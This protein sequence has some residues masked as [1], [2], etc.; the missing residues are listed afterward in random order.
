MTGK[1][2]QKVLLINCLLDG[3]ADEF[4]TPVAELCRRHTIRSATFDWRGKYG[5]IDA[6]LISPLRKLQDENRRLNKHYA[7]AQLSA[8][9]LKQAMAKVVKPSCRRTMVLTSVQLGKTSIYHACRIRGVGQRC[10]RYL[11]PICD[12]GNHAIANWLSGW[13][14]R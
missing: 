4:A 2:C 14:Q 7:E 9:L 12:Q 5:G 10:E 13:T 6:L 8:D 1:N 11:L 3:E